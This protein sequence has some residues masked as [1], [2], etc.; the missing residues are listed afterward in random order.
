M[1]EP[2]DT[3]EKAFDSTHLLHHL[4]KLG[5]LREQ[6]VDSGTGHASATS[7]PRH[8]AGLTREQLGAFVA[9]QF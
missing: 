4:S 5:V 6:L 9:V 2:S 1:F 7:N 3:F 8:S